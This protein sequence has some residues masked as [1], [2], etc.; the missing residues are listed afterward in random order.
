MAISLRMAKPGWFIAF[1]FIVLLWGHADVAAQQSAVEQID[2]IYVQSEHDN[3]QALSRLLELGQSFDTRTPY[4][5]RREFL[6]VSTFLEIDAGNVKDAARSTAQLKFLAKE[7]N[8]VSGLALATALEGGLL[9]QD[10]KS[11]AALAKLVELEPVA[12]K[13]ADVE[14][15]WHLYFF[16]GKAQLAVG[17]FEPALESLLKC[18]QFSEQ[19]KKHPKIERLK[20]LNRLSHVY[21]AMKNWDKSL[22]VI[23]EALVLAKEIDSQKMLATLYLN[24]GVVYSSQ[25]RLD[26][27]V[28][29]NNQ[30]L[31]I[32]RQSG[33]TGIEATLLLNTGDIYL[34]NH[35]YTLAER[36]SRQALVKNKEAG[37]QVGVAIAH[38]NIGIALMGQGKI[39]EGVAQARAGIKISH[40][41]EATSD[42]ED[43]LAELGRMYEQAG[44]YREAVATIR[45]QQQLSDQLFRVA[46]ER[47]VASLQEQFDAAQR[48][49]QIELLARENSLKDAEIRNHNLQQ[50]VSLLATLVAIMAGAFLFLMYRRVR[51]TNQRLVE[52]N[53]QLEFHSVRDP[54]T[55]LYNRRSFLELMKRRPSAS[56]GERREDLLEFPDGLMILDIDHFKPIND[57]LGHAVGD[58]VLVE[59]ARRLRAT[60]RDSDMVMRWGG[61]EFLVFS[62][63]T[64]A[65][66]LKGLAERLLHAV[67]EKPVVV[68]S[69]TIPVTVT[70]GFLSLPFSGLT[71]VECSWE[72][73]MQIADLALY[74]GKVHGRNRAYGLTR[75]LAPFAQA[76]PVLEHDLAAALQANLVELIE[77]VGPTPSVNL[78]SPTHI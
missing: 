32:A 15:L 1:A 48:Q 72:K 19:Q 57:S 17:R 71:E 65:S 3:A 34:R 70:G 76:M 16:L 39:A 68:G 54:L 37:D 45:E 67:G 21:I 29:A 31:K 22:D 60:V 12:V 63:K 18:L 52:V 5:V 58:A 13:D 2:A 51:H 24:Q 38:G 40:D 47:A 10:G 14:V 61:E 66:Q 44:M 6:K 8:D 9:V 50:I 41:N 62:P 59:V 46:R 27:S 74:L 55:G 11:S 56:V 25:A 73:A 26:D 53:Q 49:K 69:Q 7:Q 28:T 35:S 36:W 23:R 33:F 77:V 64:N 75:L 4:V 30:A 20:A 78:A 42:E 43:Q